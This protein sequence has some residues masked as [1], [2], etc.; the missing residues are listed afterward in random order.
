[1]PS[2]PRATGFTESLCANAWQKCPHA[3]LS[4]QC[5][6][7]R[8]RTPRARPLISQQPRTGSPQFLLQFLQLHCGRGFTGIH[9]APLP[10]SSTLRCRELRGVRSPSTTILWERRI[11]PSTGSCS[12]KSRCSLSPWA[13]SP[14]STSPCFPAR[15]FVPR[16]VTL[17]CR[18]LR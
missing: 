7:N 8:A 17:P 10:S 4:K 16:E 5:R 12:C 3:A 2:E 6:D 13:E 11:W 9:P 18:L 14:A 15:G 1:M